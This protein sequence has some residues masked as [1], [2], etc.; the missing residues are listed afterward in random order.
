MVYLIPSD[1][2]ADDISFE[3]IC[4][5]KRS[6][7]YKKWGKYLGTGN[8]LKTFHNPIWQASFLGGW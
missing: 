7:L 6:L 3:D 1:Q 4:S 5:S 8:L 2:Y